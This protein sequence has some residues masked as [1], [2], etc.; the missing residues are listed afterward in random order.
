MIVIS[1]ALP[2]FKV[3][4]PLFRPFDE[5]RLFE[6]AAQIGNLPFDRQGDLPKRS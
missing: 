4:G 6:Q 5:R 3:A 1:T 2:R